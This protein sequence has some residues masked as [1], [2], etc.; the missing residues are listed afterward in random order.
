MDQDKAIGDLT[1][2]AKGGYLPSIHRLAIV[3]AHGIGTSRNC[4][5]AVDL[6]QQ[7]AELGPLAA[8]RMRE[9]YRHYQAG[10]REESLAHYLVAAETGVELAQSNAAFLLEQGSCLGLDE[11]ACASASLRLW[12]AAAKQG[13]AEAYMKVGDFHYYGKLNKGNGSV[14]FD[15][16]SEVRRTMKVG[17]RELDRIV[18]RQIGMQE[19]QNRRESTAD[20]NTCDAAVEEE[21]GTCPARPNTPEE[22]LVLENYDNAAMYYRKA[23]DQNIPHAMFNLGYM[24]EWGI[25]VKQDFPLAKRHYDLAA[26]ANPDA[27]IP[28]QI[29]LVVMKVHERALKLW[30]QRKEEDDV[31]AALEEEKEGGAQENHGRRKRPGFLRVIV[32]HVMS[33][34][35]LCILSLLLFLFF[36]I[37][38]RGEQLR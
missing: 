32:K 30:R 5:Q 13:N 14:R 22:Q 15:V 6:F 10:R 33:L 16:L 12:K 3:K 9:G 26:A 17:V 27:N 24:Y 25:G 7:M 31:A 20:E 23:A 29:A 36:F 37:R 4:G 38:H 11:Q 19:R 35:S 28:V 1:K 8:H 18:R 2:A 21:G 34:D